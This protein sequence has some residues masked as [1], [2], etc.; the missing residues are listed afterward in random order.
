MRVL[1]MTLCFFAL[2]L[3]G[4]AGAGGYFDGWT[5]LSAVE[6]ESNGVVPGVALGITLHFDP[7]QTCTQGFGESDSTSEFCIDSMMDDIDSELPWLRTAFKHDGAGEAYGL[8]VLDVVTLPGEGASRVGQV[9]VDAG[10]SPG[11]FVLMHNDTVLAEFVVPEHANADAQ[12]PELVEITAEDGLTPAIRLVA[13]DDTHPVIRVEAE[14]ARV[15]AGGFDDHDDS[16]SV[17]LQCALSEGTISVCESPVDGV[18]LPAGSWLVRRVILWDSF[19]RRSWVE[20][21]D[22]AF[23][24]VGD[25]QAQVDTGGWPA[26]DW[27]TCEPEP[28]IA[29]EDAEERTAA[30]ADSVAP[31]DVVDFALAPDFKAVCESGDALCIHQHEQILHSLLL[32][33]SLQ[34]RHQAPGDTRFKAEATLGQN[35][36]VTGTAR[37]P[38][39]AP[40]GEYQLELHV[41]G[42]LLASLEQAPVR[43]E[44]AATAQADYATPEIVDYHVSFFDDG[45]STLMTAQI[46]TWDDAQPVR[47]GVIAINA[48]TQGPVWMKLDFEVGIHCEPALEKGLSHCALAPGDATLPRAQY[49]VYRVRFWDGAGRLGYKYPGE[50]LG[51]IPQLDVPLFP[52]TPHTDTPPAEPAGCS[53]GGPRAPAPSAVLWLLL[54]GLGSLALIRRI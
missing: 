1:S 31:G 6:L 24:I 36:M 18:V 52:S 21:G 46:V 3:P 43:L 29:A 33:G 15:D 45:D 25:P 35:G 17:S 14:L 16:L 47:Y 20:V 4:L 23:E 38:F 12:G 41:F 49:S 28:E 53:A 7:T 2:V 39:F 5:A 10:A 9:L 8:N 13:Q 37:V 40:P 26:Q 19:L 48:K 27:P 50:Q 11:R 32:S 34:F 44:V 22:V 30:P 51:C 54:F 42:E